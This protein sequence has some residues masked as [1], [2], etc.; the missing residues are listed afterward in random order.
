MASENDMG[1]IHFESDDTSTP[2]SIGALHFGASDPAAG[3][4]M[5]AEYYHRFLKQGAE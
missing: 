4:V 2:A 5:T 1:A 3:G